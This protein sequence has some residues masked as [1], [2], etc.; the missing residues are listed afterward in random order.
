M[1]MPERLR[2]L[3][4]DDY[5]SYAERIDWS[6]PK[7]T[8]EVRSITR[9]L[10]GPELAAELANT[11]VVLA[12][13]ERTPLSAEFL[14]GFDN[15]K[16]LIT[17]GMRNDAISAPPGLTYCGTGILPYPVVELTWA[18]IMGLARKLEAEQA[19]L[20]AGNWQRE[21]GTGL[22]GKTLG[23]IGLGK[24]G[25]A[26]ARIGLAFG[27]RVVAWSQN[28]DAEYAKSIGVDPVTKGELLAQS[29]VVTLHL[30]LSERSR[31]TIAEAELAMLKPSALLI[32]T[33]RAQLVNTEDLVAA[34][35]A[36]ELA[37]CGIDVFDQEPLPSSHPLLSAPNCL[38]TPHIGF[39]VEENYEIFFRDAL[40]NIAAFAAG[41]PIRVMAQ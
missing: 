34:L 19:N 37:G 38:L 32:N 23:V 17:T 31:N 27:M 40:E 7:L 30:R 35:D 29:D 9:H 26:V 22:F 39:V 6:L 11:D 18:V 28:L 41:S 10:D 4:L 2:V 14:A 33:S 21:I 20:R 3:V 24:A 12:M 15:L 16:L 36:G 5:Q 8:L 1:G 25:S 13:R